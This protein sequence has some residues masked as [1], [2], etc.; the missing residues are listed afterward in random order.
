MS[1][2]NANSMNYLPTL[3][4][5]S[6][7]ALITDPPYSSGGLHRAEKGRSPE[8]K[9]QNTHTKK[10]YLGGD[11]AGDIL[12]QRSWVRWCTEWLT[13]SRRI[14][15][16]A[17][18]ALVFIDWRQLPAMTDAFQM[19]GWT[20]RGIVV[21][22][23][24]GSARAAHKGYFRSQSE[25]I[26]WGTNGRCEKATHGGPFPGVYTQR[27]IPN[28]KLHVTG[29]PIELMRELV[30]CTPPGSRILDPF[31]GSG[32]T[33]KAAKETGRDGLGIEM[34]PE[35]FSVAQENLGAS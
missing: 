25:Y 8:T 18:Y 23:K 20:W 21:W 24:T 7:D 30:Q 12:D 2:V 34:S 26:V 22:N 13:E 35:C 11:F 16:P 3:T 4:T 17:G 31:C 32:M 33:I 5:N 9:Y 15:R 29:K 6:F 10:K 14:V 19:S 28:D 1:L 27:V